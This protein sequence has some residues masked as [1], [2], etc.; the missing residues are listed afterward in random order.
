VVGCPRSDCS[1]HVCI[2]SY[3]KKSSFNFYLCGNLE[4]DRFTLEQ[5]IRWLNPMDYS[6]IRA[7]AFLSSTRASF[8]LGDGLIPADF[9]NDGGGSK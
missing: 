5:H 8:A 3:H 9:H 7:F 2:D 4:F 6:G 1:A